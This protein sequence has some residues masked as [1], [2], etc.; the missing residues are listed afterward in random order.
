M[1]LGILTSHGGSLI[2]SA[3]EAKVDLGVI[4][5]NNSQARAFDR[6][7]ELDVPAIHLSDRTHPN[8][9]SL[10]NAINQT[11]QF[12]GCNFVLLAGYMKRLG[13]MTLNTYSGRII[14]SHPSLLPKF[15]GKGYYGRR[16]HEAVISSGETETGITIH[17]VDGEYDSGSIIDQLVVPVFPDDSAETLEN[18]VKSKE[19]PFLA[20]VISRLSRTYPK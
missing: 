19:V 6:A 9:S 5:C 13:S 8:A 3:I 16:V 17:Y 7:R 18:R 15:G 2:Q 4:I 11:L 1:K 10:D 12:H 20:D 14:N